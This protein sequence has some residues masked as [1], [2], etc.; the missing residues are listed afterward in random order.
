M[1]QDGTEVA[2]TTAT[3]PALATR[4]VHGG[5]EPHRS[6]GA[7]VMPIFQT[8]GFVFD[9]LEHGAD[10]FALRRQGFSYSRGSNPTVAA[11]ERRIAALEGGTAGV[12]IASGQAAW[13][14]AILALC[15]TGDEYV[16]SNQVF[17]GSLG[18]MK[19]LD[20]RLDVKCRLAEPTPQAVAAAVSPRTKAII[21]EGIVNPTGEV[22]DLDGI[23]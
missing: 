10:I 22:V 3:S 15:A 2:M 18:L 17:G 21:V 20:K 23:A 19:R 5:A 12:A 7:R 8:N 16:A 4:A 1:P 6:T 14:V 9:D 11:L 13:L